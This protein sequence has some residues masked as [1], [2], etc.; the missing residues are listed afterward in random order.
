MYYYTVVLHRRPGT[1]HAE[2]LD[3]WLGHHHALASALPGLIE[4]KFLPAVD[5][6]T[7]DGM[8]LLTFATQ[9]DLDAALASDQSKALRAHTAVF[10]DSDA[11]VRVIV[12]DPST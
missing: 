2:F 8:G 6:S 11:A 12:R 9:E 4:A 10:A 7:A 5:P 3:A 1:T